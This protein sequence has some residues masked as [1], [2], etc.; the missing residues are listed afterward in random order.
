[1]FVVIIAGQ[2]HMFLNNLKDDFLRLIPDQFDVEPE[3]VEAYFIN[4]ADQKAIRRAM[5]LNPNATFD[6]DFNRFV[7][8]QV[9]PPLHSTAQV[10]EN[11]E[12]FTVDMEECKPRIIDLVSFSAKKV[13]SIS[14]KPQANSVTG[15]V[16][17]VQGEL[18]LADEV[19]ENLLPP[20]EVQE[21]V[22][23]QDEPA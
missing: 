11:G 8:T 17:Q 18:V 16:S 12:P 3:E 5:K 6:Y 19:T 14:L 2:K 23:P 20:E 4:E 10:Q 9:L 1:M 22:E 7:L 13:Q 21:S 15:E